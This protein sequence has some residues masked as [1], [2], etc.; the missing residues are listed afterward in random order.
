MNVHIL[1]ENVNRRL[2]VF[3][4]EEV[5]SVVNVVSGSEM[6]ILFVTWGGEDRARNI[7]EGIKYYKVRRSEK[8]IKGRN[9]NN[10]IITYFIE[11]F[12]EK[13][14]LNVFIF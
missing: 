4:T 10:S 7:S 8:E 14:I 11:N 13:Y 3:R 5:V 6:L 2:V 1:A 12:T 9:I